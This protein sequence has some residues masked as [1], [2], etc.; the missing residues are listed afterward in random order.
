[1]CSMGW[2]CRHRSD[3]FSPVWS[4]LLVKAF[5]QSQHSYSFS[6]VCVPSGVWQLELDLKNF[7]H[8]L[9]LLQFF[10]SVSSQV[11]PKGWSFPILKTFIW[12]L[13]SMRLSIDFKGW[14]ITTFFTLIAFL[15]GVIS[16]G[17]KKKSP[18]LLM[19]F[20]HRVHSWSFSPGWVDTY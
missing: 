1:M 7:P 18:F 13:A 17:E 2:N 3:S 12:F 10:Y 6:Q 11:C 5:L 4:L 14:R 20:P 15:A 16:L 8:W 9:I 19:T